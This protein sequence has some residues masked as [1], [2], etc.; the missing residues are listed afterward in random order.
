MWRQA[1]PMRVLLWQG[2]P[3]KGTLGVYPSDCTYLFPGLHRLQ[4]TARRTT[5]C[6]LHRKGWL[7]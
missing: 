1:L 6:K 5:V 2:T 4:E 7:V 3:A